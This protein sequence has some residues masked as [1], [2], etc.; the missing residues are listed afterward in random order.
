MNRFPFAVVFGFFETFQST[1][2]KRTM[3]LEIN[4]DENPRREEEIRKLVSDVKG[5]GD[6]MEVVE[7]AMEFQVIFKRGKVVPN[8]FQ[9]RVKLEMGF[10]VCTVINRFVY[11]RK[12]DKVPEFSETP[13]RKNAHGGSLFGF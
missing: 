11:K 8:T 6:H 5:L 9:I 7:E 3:E 4:W 2:T 12:M 13:P 1:G 10:A